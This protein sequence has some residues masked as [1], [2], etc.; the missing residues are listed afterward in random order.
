MCLPVHCSD[1]WT[2]VN[3]VC[4]IT[5]IEMIT[6]GALALAEISVS[7]LLRMYTQFLSFLTVPEK[8]NSN[9]RKNE[10]CLLI[11]GKLMKEWQNLELICTSS[12]YV[13]IL[14]VVGRA[15][16]SRY[17]FLVRSAGEIMSKEI[18]KKKRVLPQSFTVHVLGI[19]SNEFR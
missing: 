1:V 5:V 4:L 16:G 8:H 6:A 12:I 2:S 10:T 11:F 17:F 13:W 14:L 15:F 3:P 9:L 18:I 19:N 7:R